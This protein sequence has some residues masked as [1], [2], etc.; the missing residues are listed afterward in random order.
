[1]NA[2]CFSPVN[3]PEAFGIVKRYQNNKG[4]SALVVVEEVPEL[5]FAK[6]E[7]IRVFDPYYNN[8]RVFVYGPSD[9]PGPIVVLH[10]SLGTGRKFHPESVYALFDD[11]QLLPSSVRGDLPERYKILVAQF[12]QREI[13][14]LSVV[15]G[16]TLLPTPRW[17]RVK[18]PV[19]GEE[20]ERTFCTLLGEEVPVPGRSHPNFPHAI[21]RGKAMTLDIEGFG[22]IECQIYGMG[23][24]YPAQELSDGSIEPS[25]R[26]L[27]RANGTIYFPSA[28][29][30]AVFTDYFGTARRTR[31][32]AVP[33]SP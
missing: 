31:R 10:R 17:V 27:M 8:L 15:N 26:P 6:A 11:E 9:R 24:F 22:T 16:E 20:G 32:D 28:H 5:G 14:Y 30:W 12:E 2:C 4:V 25:I 29:S 1:M 18:Y 33:V 23:A 19:Q 3:A 21:N 13:D 7:P